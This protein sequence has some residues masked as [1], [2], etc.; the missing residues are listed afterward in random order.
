[1]DTVLA[2]IFAVPLDLAVEIGVREG[3]GKFHATVAFDAPDGVVGRGIK[4]RP[5]C[6]GGR[7][8]ILRDARPRPP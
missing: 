7:I 4:V 5:R 6:N 2:G 1:M 8:Q 3:L